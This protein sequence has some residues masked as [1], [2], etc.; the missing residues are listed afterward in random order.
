MRVL[1]ADVKAMC[2]RFYGLSRG[3]ME[4]ESRARRVARPRQVAMTLCRHYSGATLPSIG[5]R[6]HRDHTTVLHAIR[7]VDRLC[8]EDVSFFAELASLCGQ[9]EAGAI[10]CPKA[11]RS[12]APVVVQ[13]DEAA[14]PEIAKTIVA[15]D[16]FLRRLAAE[17]ERSATP[18]PARSRRFAEHPWT[19]AH[20]ASVHLY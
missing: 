7:A 19:G 6:F 1:A 16:E 12:D 3:E 8:A 14:P 15:P 9:I 13:C 4:G 17:R 2:A 18:P 20:C 10:S 5:R 11:T